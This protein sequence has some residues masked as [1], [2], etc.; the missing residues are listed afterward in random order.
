MYERNA[1]LKA[2]TGVVNLYVGGFQNS[3]LKRCEKHFIPRS[4]VWDQPES[5]D[6]C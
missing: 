5:R 3:I 6:H 2:I 4:D 1:K